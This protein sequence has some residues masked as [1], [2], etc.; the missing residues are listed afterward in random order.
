[1][2]H[3]FG[4]DLLSHPLTVEGEHMKLLSPMFENKHDD[5]VDLSCINVYPK[6]SG[7]LPGVVPSTMVNLEYTSWTGMALDA[8]LSRIYGGIHIASS[9]YP[10]TQVGKLV[11]NSV[12]K[13][14]A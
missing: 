14:F 6:S 4:D 10:G 11:S 8:G 7:I 1:M 2:I 3:L 5:V 13:Q 9:N 12:L